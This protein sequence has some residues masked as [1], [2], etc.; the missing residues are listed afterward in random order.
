MPPLRLP[1]LEILELSP[2][3]SL[4]IHHH[5]LQNL[6]GSLLLSMPTVSLNL[7]SFIWITYRPHQM[8]FSNLCLHRPPRP[9]GSFP[10][11]SNTHCVFRAI[12]VCSNLAV[13]LVPTILQN[14]LHP[15]ST[16]RHAITVFAFGLPKIS[17]NNHPHPHTSFTSLIL[18]PS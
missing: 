18:G 5:I 10:T 14:P 1:K 8:S 16:S 17:E 15:P 6:S 12:Q 9:P 13:S 7:D 2:S 3:A 11:E 4:L